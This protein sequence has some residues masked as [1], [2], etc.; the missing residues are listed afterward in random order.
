M[1]VDQ[2][3]VTRHVD[4]LRRRSE[5]VNFGNPTE[6]PIW[7]YM[8]TEDSTDEVQSDSEI[9]ESFS[10]NETS[11]AQE[12]E[13]SR[14]AQTLSCTLQVRKS[15]ERPERKLSPFGNQAR[16]TSKI[17]VVTRKSGRTNIGKPPSR[18]GFNDA[19]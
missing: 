16:V 4:H 1:Q 13:V 6:V 2:G 9:Y 3:I 17:P 10:D 15:A 11:A 7:A 14:A 18:L 5:K 8:D 12:K 19:S